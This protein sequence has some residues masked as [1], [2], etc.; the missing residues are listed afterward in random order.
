MGLLTES[1]KANK[2]IEELG[3]KG[4]SIFGYSIVLMILCAIVGRSTES[5]TI[6]QLGIIPASLAFVLF[7][8]LIILNY[9]GS[10]ISIIFYRGEKVYDFYKEYQQS[11][12][13]SY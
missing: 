9:F 5:K 7:I 10:T 4:L 1:E 11:Y 3:S 13:Q 2:K 6:L 12:Q 8:F